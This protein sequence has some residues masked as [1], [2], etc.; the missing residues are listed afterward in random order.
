MCG[1]VSVKNIIILYYSCFEIRNNASLPACEIRDQVFTECGT[2][3]PPVCGEEQPLFCTLQC[4]V[5]CQCPPG[6]LLDRVAN[7]C[8]TECPNG[9]CIH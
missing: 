6:T 4:V 1:I 5:G 9:M 7:E 8:V 3:C 2:A